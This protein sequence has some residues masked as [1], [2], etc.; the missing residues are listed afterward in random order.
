MVDRRRRSPPLQNKFL[1]GTGTLATGGTTS[2]TWNL[3]ER[4]ADLIL[5]RMRGHIWARAGSTTAN[6][7]MVFALMS[8]KEPAVPSFADRQDERRNLWSQQC[9][10]FRDTTTNVEETADLHFDLSLKIKVPLDR[11]LYF[12][13]FNEGSVT[14]FFEWWVRLFWTL[15]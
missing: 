6:E 9:C 5:R 14:D 8:M 7:S 13:V 11:L 10:T 2:S 15:I 4:S 12:T 3:Q 1:L